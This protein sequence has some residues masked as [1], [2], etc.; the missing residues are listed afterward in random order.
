MQSAAACTICPLR[1]RT[2]SDLS[3]G[4]LWVRFS[5]GQDIWVALSLQTQWAGSVEPPKG[6]LGVIDLGKNLDP[7][8]HLNRRQETA[9]VVFAP[10]HQF[11]WPPVSRLIASAI[12]PMI[13]T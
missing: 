8:A 13:S 11:T 9:D 4:S 7:L 10:A 12:G 3:L 1:N 2:V 6:I 5:E